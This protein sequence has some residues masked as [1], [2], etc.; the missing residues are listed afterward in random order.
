MLKFFVVLTFLSWEIVADANCRGCCSRH[1]GVVC[2]NG[3]TQCGD[4]SSLSSK[5]SAKG[6]T[7][8]Q[9]EASSPKSPKA[10][11]FGGEYKRAYFGS[12]TD[13]DKNCLDTRNEIL[14]SRSLVEV[15]IVRAKSGKCRVTTGK[16]RDFY[17]NEVLTDAGKIDI[18]H[19]VPLRHAWE[20]GAASWSGSK[21][22]VF[23]EDLEN[24]VITNRKY[25]RQ[26]GAKTILEW[27]PIN[28]S[29]ACKYALKWFH[30]KNKYSLQ[31]SQL[32]RDYLARL[33]CS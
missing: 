23:S 3:V 14:K 2:V 9:G 12:W 22:K 7:K 15:Q 10:T 8:C 1:K 32:E 16:W 28:R 20:T 21:R 19:I 6:C 5:C 31:V 33:K 11:P 30:V 27:M 13:K 24:L 4:G 26:K 29:Y 17:Y 18:D 25:N